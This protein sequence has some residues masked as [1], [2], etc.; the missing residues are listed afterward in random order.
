MERECDVS[1]KVGVMEGMLQYQTDLLSIRGVSDWIFLVDS[2]PGTLA[3]SNLP[4][5]E[6]LTVGC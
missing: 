6:T 1:H 5:R 4:S 3:I 2:V